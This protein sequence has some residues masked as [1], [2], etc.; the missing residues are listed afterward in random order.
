[1]TTRIVALSGSLRS[2]SFNTAL[3]RDIQ[4]HASAGTVVEIYDYK[5]VP[6][7]TGDLDHTPDAVTRL[8]EAITQADGVLIATPEFNYS[9][10]GVLKNAIDWASRP[11]YHSPFRDKPVAM[12]SS[13]PS[14]LG[15]VRAQQHLKTILLGM[16]ASVFS[17]PEVVVPAVHQKVVDGVL[18]DETTRTFLRELTEA[19]AARIGPA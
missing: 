9:V 11:A 18:V 15:G 2:A 13:S 10:P 6:L 8:R 1:M 14:F 3:L 12:F 7:Y 5:D 19:F 4:A 17:W 16:A